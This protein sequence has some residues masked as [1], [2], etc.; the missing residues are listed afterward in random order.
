MCRRTRRPSRRGSG[1]LE[2]TDHCGSLRAADD[3]REV[4]LC[5][6]AATR[7]D[8]GGLIFVDLRDRA[9]RVQLTFRP[10]EAPA[11]HETAKGIRAETVLAVRGVVA[12]RGDEQ[13]NPKL[14]TGDVEVVVRQIEILNPVDPLPFPVEE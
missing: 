4:V 13:R 10:E 6:W 5:G 8:H 12:L 1:M 9:G 14:E 2:R 7:R 11:A 3:G